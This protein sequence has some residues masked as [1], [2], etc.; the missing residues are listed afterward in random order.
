MTPAPNE[1]DQLLVLRAG[2]G[3]RAAYQ[4]L[5][6]RHVDAAWRRLGRLVGP[7]AERED[8]IQQAFFEVFQG[9]T[10]FRGEASFSTYLGRVLVNMACDHLRRRGR[11]PLPVP[12]EVLELVE[13]PE[14]SP[15]RTAQSRERLSLIWGLLDRINPKK[16]V[17]FVLHEVEG[18]SLAEVGAVMDISA[19]T[20]RKRVEHAQKELRA[21]LGR[22]GEEP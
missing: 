9:L 11:R 1:V 7:D 20:A 14:A 6:Q 12:G 4:E 22:R 10:R 2:R 21:M 18:L 19:D 13:A 3:D 15:E 17:A 16:R 5:Y 8:L